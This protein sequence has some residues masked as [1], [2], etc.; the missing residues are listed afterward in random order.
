MT[1]ICPRVTQILTDFSFL[2]RE[3]L[4]NLRTDRSNRIIFPILKPNFGSSAFYR[5]L[6]QMDADS[7]SIP[8][9]FIGVHLRQK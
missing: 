2:I 5:Q 6:M 8:F 7:E 1:F 3:N 9:A 4:C